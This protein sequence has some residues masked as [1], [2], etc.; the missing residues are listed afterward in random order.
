MPRS[1]AT[2]APCVAI[3]RPTLLENA[4][5]PILRRCARGARVAYGREQASMPSQS[6][7]DLVSKFDEQELRNAVDQTLREVRTRF[8]LRDSKTEIIQEDE[9]L[10]VNTDS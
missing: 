9:Q 6:S 5:A 10:L 1:L 3:P 7:F 2:P 8:D 4:L